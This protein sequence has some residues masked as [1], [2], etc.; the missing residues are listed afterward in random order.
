MIDEYMEAQADRVRE[1]ISDE[2]IEEMYKA[3]FDSIDTL[4]GLRSED[5]P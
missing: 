1:S 5:R 2:D 4:E 3:Y